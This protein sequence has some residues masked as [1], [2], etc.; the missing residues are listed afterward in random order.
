M[1]AAQ[2]VCGV[3]V[4]TVGALVLSYDN[5]TVKGA[6]VDASLDGGPDSDSEQ[7]THRA[8]GAHKPSRGSYHAIAAADETA[9][10]RSKLQ[11][12][13]MQPNARETRD[14]ALMMSMAG[15][16]WASAS[17]LEKLGLSADS[18]VHAQHF[19][20]VQKVA[21]FVAPNRP[22][23]AWPSSRGLHR[24]LG[25]TAR[26]RTPLLSTAQSLMALP[27]L[28]NFL[29][30]RLGVRAHKR[31]KPVPCLRRRVLALLLLS[32]GLVSAPP[33][34]TRHMASCPLRSLPR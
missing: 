14:A 5:A 27:L 15:L 18:R 17:S 33:L 10:A 7:Q 2:G 23:F 31:A 20:C 25:L 24:L 29:Y 16:C 34:E 3:I 11:G 8:N 26:T 4:L 12:V 32:A 1:P 19:L 28:V 13:P 21:A 6:P 9:G 30:R 22:P